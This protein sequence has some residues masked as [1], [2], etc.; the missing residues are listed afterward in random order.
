M[1]T[2]PST[3]YIIERTTAV[4]YSPASND[5]KR[6]AYNGITNQGGLVVKD[7]RWS[8]TEAEESGKGI[9]VA[10]RKAPRTLKSIRRNRFG[11]LRHV[12]KTRGAS[13]QRAINKSLRSPRGVCRKVRLDQNPT[14]KK[15][16]APARVLLQD[17]TSP[18]SQVK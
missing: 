11:L 8:S 17:A 6:T 12:C 9:V 18:R 10:F 16:Q 13:S 7:R 5:G 15:P 14:I 2:N 3:Y 4:V 1:W